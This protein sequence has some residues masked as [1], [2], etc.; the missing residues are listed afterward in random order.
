M[1]IIDDE[2]YAAQR[3][4][5]FVSEKEE[6]S[7]TLAASLISDGMVSVNGR[8]ADKNYKLRL[9]DEVFVTLP[10]P[11]ADSATA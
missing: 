9:G 2:L 6:I 1:G 4:D 3:L 10:E 5:K 11:S 7:R 8:L